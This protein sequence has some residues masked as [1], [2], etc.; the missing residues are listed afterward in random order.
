MKKYL[1]F[2]FSVYLIVL[3]AFHNTAVAQ[4][5]SYIPTTNLIGFWPL[6]SNFLNTFA[7]LHHGTN[8][9]SIPAIGKSGI[10]SVG[11]RF[12]GSTAFASLPS[13]VMSQVSGSFSV[14]IW[15]N[16]DSTFPNPLG[17]D[18]INDRTSGQWTFRFRLMF[19]QTN[20]GTYSPDSAYMDHISGSSVLP[21]ASAP[22]PSIEGW[23]HYVLVYDGS[24]TAGVMR[25]YHN[26]VLSGVSPTT[27]LIPGARPI[28]IGRGLSPGLPGGYGQFRGTIDEIAIWNRALSP[29]EIV[30]IFQACVL[31]ITSQPQNQSVSVGSTASFSITPTLANASI[32][33]QVDTTGGSWM[34][35]LNS[36]SI[37]GTSTTTLTVSNVGRNLNGALFR[38]LVSDSTCTGASTVA[39]LNVNCVSLLNQSP[40]SSTQQIGNTVNFVTG[41]LVPGTQY[42]WQ[43]D[44]G[45]GFQTIFNFGQYTGATTNTLSVSSLTRL[46]NGYRFRCLLSNL[47]CVDTSQVA[48]LTVLCDQLIS[49]QPADF[50]GIVGGSATFSVNQISGGN[51]AWFLNNGLSFT[52]V[53]NGGQFSGATT[54]N[55]QISNL[56]LTN[57]NT[58]YICLVTEGDCSDTTG[59]ALLRVST[60]TNT[61]NLNR[62]PWKTY[63]NPVVNWL[64]IDLSEQTT[65]IEVSIFDHS[66][67]RCYHQLMEPGKHQIPVETWA[68]GLYVIG[69]GPEFQ[70]MLVHHP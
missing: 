28:N 59:I 44:L 66:G 12:N 51:Y 62:N 70:R 33:W 6:D 22:Y 36:A 63:P 21:R 17:Y 61:T 41:S 27:I 3:L 10:N 52:T 2:T 69:V 35:L 14:S 37:S 47:G 29:S 11:M 32:Q 1:F 31:S 15:L 16:T 43:V 9:G 45:G 57:N 20:F 46:N 5:P 34:P 54:A 48:T 19:G 68:N 50:N 30:T 64:Y 58:A 40:A 24:N 25:I 4:V 53:N 26:G 60:G 49:S 38:A 8:S 67:R 39:T 18:P 7:P 23:T 42:Q 65:A 13:T 55:L 56:N